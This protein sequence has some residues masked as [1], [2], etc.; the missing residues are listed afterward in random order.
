[1]AEHE[2]ETIEAWLAENPKPQGGSPW[3]VRLFVG[4]SA[5]IASLFMIGFM[6]FTGIIDS[7][8]SALV[9][10]V[11]MVAAGI[12][13]NWTIERNDFTNQFNLALCLTGEILFTV[14]LSE[15][16]DF[17]TWPTVL[18]L[19]GLEIVIFIFFRDTFHRVLSVLII[20]GA[21][22]FLLVDLSFIEL[23]HV[24]VTVIAGAALILFGW[25]YR[26]IAAGRAEIL[27]PLRYGLGISLLGVLYLVLADEFQLMWWLSAVGLG[28][29][30]VIL[31]VEVVRDLHL[32]EPSKTMLWGLVGVAALFIPATRMPGIFAALLILVAGFWRQNRLEQGF[33]ALFL[34]FYLGGYYYS[35]EWTLLVK[36]VA[37]MVTGGVLFALRAWLLIISKRGQL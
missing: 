6:A 28:G 27:R 25:E 18:A 23:I 31:S 10:G 33:G 4:L 29:L 11:I 5:W 8:E 7:E 1:M 36:S 37:L 17:E 3:F 21:L 2:P 35:L 32:P 13:S 14:G 20:N 15:L 12:A 22:L 34:I 26:L 16:L 24:L 19:I 9:F 30:L